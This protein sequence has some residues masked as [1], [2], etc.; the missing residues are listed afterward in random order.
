MDDLLGVRAACALHVLNEGFDLCV[1]RRRRRGCGGSRGSCRSSRWGR[2]QGSSGSGGR[3][4]SRGGGGQSGAHL[5]K[6]CDAGSKGPIIASDGCGGVGGQ[7][8]V[9]RRQIHGFTA[10]T[11]AAA[12]ACTGALTGVG[13]SLGGGTN[14][15]IPC[16]ARKCLMISI[17]RSID[18]MPSRWRPRSIFP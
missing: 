6:W 12:L 2:G 13:R 3:G 4:A 7:S 11:S 18:S 8:D 16:G 1:E 9:R 10:A 17:D 14:S 5:C 15:G